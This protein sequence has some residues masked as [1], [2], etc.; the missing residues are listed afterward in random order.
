V[1]LV[2]LVPRFAGAD[3][4]SDCLDAHGEAQLLRRNGRIGAARARLVACSV[5]GCPALVSRDC[6]A[7]LSELD[8]EQPTVILAAHDDLGRDVGILRVTLD[9]QPFATK[10][11]GRPIDVDPG[12]HVVRGQFPDGRAVELTVV[13]RATEKDRVIRLDLPRRAERPPPPPPPP[14]P[15]QPPAAEGP[16]VFTFVIG[17]IGVVGLA[18][19][20]YF[21]LTGRFQESRL[22]SR[23]AP[24]CSEDDLNGVR[25]SY[26]AADI[27][28]GVAIVAIGAATWFALTARQGPRP[29]R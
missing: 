12:S 26:L 13:V 11:D 20:A 5:A 29:A 28:L 14:P 25:R 15:P 2:A 4:K 3:E 7:W 19:F 24:N 22:A 9:G 17:G 16:P 27:S 21:G 18:S 8:A 6:T 10:L 23:C 1:L